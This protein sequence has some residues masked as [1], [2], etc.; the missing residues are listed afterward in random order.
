MEKLWNFSSRRVRYGGSQ[1]W[2]RK[3]ADFVL[4]HGIND[5]ARVTSR[6]QRPTGKCSTF[7]RRNDTSIC[8]NLL[9]WS[10][11]WRIC[12][13]DE[14]RLPSS[15]LR[16]PSAI[17]PRPSSPTRSMGCRSALPSPLDR[18]CKSLDRKRG[19]DTAGRRT[20]SV[21]LTPKKSYILVK[22]SFMFQIQ[23]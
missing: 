22:S 12:G 5:D 9:L 14:A 15:S 13:N 20:S 19:S 8:C 11:A 16:R 7:S 6:N 2:W 4:N 23:W 10:K 17:S 1:L 21:L 3:S 18:R